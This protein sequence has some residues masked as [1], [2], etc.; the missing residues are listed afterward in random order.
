MRIPHKTAKTESQRATPSAC[1]AH[2]TAAWQT[3]V[4]CGYRLNSQQ[5]QTPSQV[6]SEPKA[7][8]ACH[9][10]DPGVSLALED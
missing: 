10:Q 6:I 3:P 9:G 2:F 5:N 7:N 8:L 4:N 1:Q